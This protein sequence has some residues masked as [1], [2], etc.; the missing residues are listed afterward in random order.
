MKIKVVNFHGA[1]KWLVT[2]Q[3]IFVDPLY[4]NELYSRMLPTRKKA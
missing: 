3:L 1:V 2:N 4:L